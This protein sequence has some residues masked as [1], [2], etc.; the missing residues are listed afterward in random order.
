MTTLKLN[1]SKLNCAEVL[2]LAD[3][4]LTRLAPPAPEAP[5][6]IGLAAETASM[7]S[8][9]DI[10]FA[11]NKAYEDAKAALVTLKETRDAAVQN[12]RVEEKALAD[13]VS[14]KAKGDPVTLADSGFSLVNEP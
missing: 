13:A 12:L 7:Q 3:I 8:A 6:I 2:A 9:R 11:A 14:A 4:V 10:A 5:S 1:L